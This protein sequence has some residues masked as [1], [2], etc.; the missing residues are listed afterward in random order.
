MFKVFGF[1]PKKDGL[2]T[3]EF[4]DYYENKHVPLICRLAP[5]PIIYK[6]RYLGERLTCGEIDF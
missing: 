1:L 2:G 4:I 6:R 3:Q 5:V